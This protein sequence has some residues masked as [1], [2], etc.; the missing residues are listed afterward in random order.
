MDSK[1][2][3]KLLC[4]ISYRLNKSV[5][6]AIP[7]KFFRDAWSY[8]GSMTSFTPLLNSQ[9]LKDRR[10]TNQL[11]GL[12]RPCLQVVVLLEKTRNEWSS[13]LRTSAVVA[14]LMR[15]T[16]LLSTFF[17]N[18]LGYLALQSLSA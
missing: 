13:H 5:N 2:W 4:L 14:D 7:G 9:L 15:K 18:A 3:S 16:R 10:R 1:S 12:D 8:P 11:I 6:L 17:V